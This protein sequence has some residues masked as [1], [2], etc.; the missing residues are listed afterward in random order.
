MSYHQLERELS[1]RGW[2]MQR[3]ILLI[4]CMV[5]ALVLS[6]CG[7]SSGSSSENSEKISEYVVFDEMNESMQEMYIDDLGFSRE[8]LSSITEEDLNICY[9]EESLDDEAKQWCEVA[10][11]TEG[12]GD[13]YV[14]SNTLESW[15][16]ML[17]DDMKLNEII[18]PGS[19]DA[20]M[21]ECN[22]PYPIIPFKKFIVGEPAVRA[23][24]NLTLT[25]SLNI[26]GQLTFGTRYFDIRTELRFGEPYTYHRTDVAGADV[27]CTGDSLSNI[28]SQVF[29]FLKLH[30][31]ETVILKFSHFRTV[32]AMNYTIAMTDSFLTEARDMIYTST[33]QRNL[34]DV[35]LKELRGKAVFLYYDPDHNTTVN[36][37]LGRH[38]YM[39]AAQV[40]YNKNVV[41]AYYIPWPGQNALSVFDEYA[42]T[43]TLETMITDQSIK[44][45]KVDGMNQPYLSLLS[46]TLTPPSNWFKA[47]HRVNEAAAGKYS[48]KKLAWS[49]EKRPPTYNTPKGANWWLPL[50][51]VSSFNSGRNMPNIVYYD[52]IEPLT[53]ALIINYNFTTQP[54]KPI[55]DRYIVYINNAPSTY[56]YSVTQSHVA[57]GAVFPM[58]YGVLTYQDLIQDGKSVFRIDNIFWSTEPASW[59][60]SVP[61][62]PGIY[63]VFDNAEKLKLSDLKLQE[64]AY[65]VGSGNH[66]V[67]TMVKMPKV[68]T[69]LE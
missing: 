42:D 18:M 61:K 63:P 19:H 25:Q 6:G 17:P 20:G 57:L 45:I 10:Y 48:I 62:T 41:N 14:D 27:G 23:Q 44:Q 9:D 51:L 15:M 35:P 26:F 56:L 5:L 29:L 59:W 64:Y 46:W 67:Y 7:S 8:L 68:F 1:S 31:A 40:D 39:E 65:W 36:S 50:Q 37:L 38:A 3:I 22:D 13:D 66:F 58:T 47:S 60:S 33:T 24:R 34:A 49:Q 21:Y 16:G 53:N 69:T 12:L 32:E 4:A 54:Q 2:M 43:E 30:K 11:Y 55:S 52:Y 28:L